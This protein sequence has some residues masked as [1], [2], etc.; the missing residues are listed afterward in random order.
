MRE[1][2]LSVV[3]TFLPLRTAC[4]ETTT[5][6]MT[7]VKP[8]FVYGLGVPRHPDLRGP[9]SKSETRAKMEAA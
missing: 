5:P 7:T 8:D 6:A 3:E 1:D 4:A 9:V 2:C